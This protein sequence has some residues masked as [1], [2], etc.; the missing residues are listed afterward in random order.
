MERDRRRSRLVLAATA[1]SVAGCLVLC[2][3]GIWLMTALVIVDRDTY[4]AVRIGQSEAEVRDLLPDADVA[5]AEVVGGRDVP[6]AVCVD[7][8]ASILDRHDTDADLGQTLYRFCF[9]D[10]VLVD[11]QIFQEQPS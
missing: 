11:K 1:L 9:R 6:G 5:V 7:Y 4:D 8:H 3:A 10:G 2:V